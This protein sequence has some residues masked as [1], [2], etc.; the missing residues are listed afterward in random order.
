GFDGR[1]VEQ[2]VKEIVRLKREG[3]MNVLIVSSGA[4]GCG[5]NVLGLKNRP[6]DLPLKQ[7]TAAVGQSRLMH[8]YEVLFQTYG[9]GLHTA[10][11]LLSGGDL[12]DRHRYL[13][14]RN[15]VHTL[16]ELGSV[17]PVVN[18]N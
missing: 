1:V 16:F 5:M 9:D 14:I 7:A 11:V 2:V 18:E 10:Q 6:K 8:Y 4:V 12:D 17:V 13:N 15:T 3:T